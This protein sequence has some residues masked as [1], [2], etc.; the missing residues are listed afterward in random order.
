MMAEIAKALGV[1]DQPGS[2]VLE[3]VS[4]ALRGT[5]S[6]LVVDNLEQIPDA[7]V[8][9]GALLR[10]DP[11][12]TLLAT[13]RSSLRIS[14]ERALWVDPLRLESGDEPSDAVRL[15]SE[16]AG[17]IGSFALTDANGDVHAVCRR[18]DG[19]P[20]AI[21]LA[22]ARTRSLSPEA[23]L[24]RI[25]QRLTL[26]SGGPVD[27]PERQRAL[28][29]HAGVELRPARRDRQVAFRLLSSIPAGFGLDV[30]A[31]VLDRPR[32]R[33]CL[34]R[35]PPGPIA[36]DRHGGRRTPRFGMLQTVRDFGRE[37]IAEDSGNTPRLDLP[38]YFPPALPRS[39]PAQKERGAR[40]AELVRPRTRER[41]GGDLLVG[42]ARQRR[43]GVGVGHCIFRLLVHTGLI[44]GGDRDI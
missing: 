5:V 27:L 30:A 6:L 12:L 43:P 25:S 21:E 17:L 19:L 15:F 37:Q 44:S 32:T 39:V 8:D 36:R 38:A 9:S 2:T 11:G 34:D 10:A 31:A 4:A 41:E 42:C 14:G 33:R 40:L 24:A 7:G 3:L 28:H 23:L 22:A 1:R 13:S 35:D 18:L 26:L 20:L 16:R 29:R